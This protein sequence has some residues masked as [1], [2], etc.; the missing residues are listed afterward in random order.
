[1]DTLRSNGSNA[2]SI[3]SKNPS[4]ALSKHSAD[5]RSR[6]LPTQARHN[7]ASKP[8]H[9][10]TLA[11]IG[12][13]GAD[14]VKGAAGVGKS[15]LCNRL[16]RPHF[17]DFNI[18]H[19]S[20]L[21]QADFAC[22]RVINNDHWLYWG[23]TELDADDYAGKTTHVRIIE[24]TVFLDDESFEPLGNHASRESRTEDYAK[25]ALKTSLES[26]DKLMYICRDQ[27]GQES[28]FICHP[29]PDAKT[30]VEAFCVVFDVSKIE[31]RPVQKQSAF[32]LQLLVQALKT[33]KPVFL[34]AT[35][36]DVADPEALRE[37]YKLAQRKELKSAQ[38]HTA[39]VSALQNVNIA[40]FLYLV[41]YLADKS[42][43]RP[44]MIPYSEALGYRN[45][46]IARISYDFHEL[47]A[48]LLPC[49][50]YPVKRGKVTWPIL[51]ADFD[52]SCHPVY[53]AFVAEF[54]PKTAR[55]AFEEHERACREWWFEHDLNSRLPSL[56]E[57]LRRMLDRSVLCNAKW[58]IIHAEL[59]AHP[60]FDTYFQPLGRSLDRLSS[61]IG[62]CSSSSTHSQ[63]YYDD[64][65]PG[66]VLAKPE[67]Q[68]LFQ[69]LQKELLDEI[70][71]E[72]QAEKFRNLLAQ[73][74]AVTPGRSFKDARV[75]VEEIAA[76]ER[77]LPP[78]CAYR[79]YTT[80]Q[81]DLKRQARRNFSELLL[82]NI[83]L[84][85]DLVVDWR[86]HYSDL[87]MIGLNEKDNNLVHE[88]LCQDKRYRDMNGLTDDRQNAISQF[89]SF[90]SL[91]LERHC[92][93]GSLCADLVLPVAIDNQVHDQA[94]FLSVDLE[95]HGDLA[96]AQ[97]FVGAVKTITSPENVFNYNGY[98]VRFNAFVSPSLEL[99]NPYAA[100]LSS[101]VPTLIYLLNSA[102]E[103]LFDRIHQAHFRNHRQRWIPPIF[104]QV[105][106]PARFDS[107]P[108]LH[109][110][111]TKL[112]ERFQGVFVG[113]SSVHQ[114]SGSSSSSVMGH[115]H[116]RFNSTTSHYDDLS[117]HFRWEQITRVLR[118]ACSAQLDSGYYDLRVRLSLFCG[119][120]FPA[121][122]VLMP[123][124]DHASRSDASGR[125]FSMDVRLP[126]DQH[127]V[128]VSVNVCSYHNWLLSRWA[129]NSFQGHILVYSPTRKASWR[130]AKTAARMLINSVDE[131][132]EPSAFFT[133][134]DVNKM[135]LKGSKLAEEI[136]CEFTAV[137]PTRNHASQVQTYVDFFQRLY[138]NPLLSADYYTISN[139]KRQRMSS[140]PS[141]VSSNT[142]TENNLNRHQK[143]YS[144]TKGSTL[145]GSARTLLSDYSNSSP[146]IGS[147]K[148]YL[149]D[150]HKTVEDR[151]FCTQCALSSLSTKN[152]QNGALE[153]CE[154]SCSFVEVNS[155]GELASTMFS[156][157]E[158]ASICSHP[159]HTS[160]DS[161][162]TTGKAVTPRNPSERG[163]SAI[164][165]RRKGIRP[166]S[167]IFSEN[168]L[169]LMTSSVAADGSELRSSPMSM[170]GKAQR[171]LDKIISS[172]IQLR[173]SDDDHNT[174]KPI[175]TRNPLQRHNSIDKFTPPS[176]AEPIRCPLN[177]ASPPVPPPKP[178]NLL[179]Q[180]SQT[181]IQRSLN[182]TP[183]I[184]HRPK[185]DQ[186]SRFHN[187]VPLRLVINPALNGLRKGANALSRSMDSLVVPTV[188]AIEDEPVLS[189]ASNGHAATILS[190]NTSDYVGPNQYRPF[191]RQ[192][193]LR[194]RQRN[195]NKRSL[196]AS[197][198]RNQSTL[199]S[200][201]VNFARRMASS[202]RKKKV[203]ANK[204][205]SEVSDSGLKAGSVASSSAFSWLPHRSPKRQLRAKSEGSSQW[206]SA[207]KSSTQ[208][209]ALAG[210]PS[211]DATL[212]SLC[213]NP[214][215]LPVFLTKCLEFIESNGGMEMEGL[216]RVP[217]NQSQV[218]ELEKAFR[219]SD[220]V[221]LRSINIPVH[222]TATALKKFLDG[223]QEPLI[224]TKLDESPTSVSRNITECQ[225][226]R[227]TRLRQAVEENIP[228]LNRHILRHLMQHFKRVAD[229]S[230]ANSMDMRNLSKVWGPTLFR[231][232]FDSF[233]KMASSLA[234]F[235]MAAYVMLTN[236]DSIFL[237]CSPT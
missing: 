90:V 165:A 183:S 38:I 159:R 61:G 77:A 173:T 170:S 59:E 130:H 116:D 48:T 114:R 18:E 202:W 190:A 30:N 127:N 7:A 86:L 146:S 60:E 194:D 28:D 215:R 52:L 70:S 102:E 50:E 126:L 109:Q 140:S 87:P 132:N 51:L 204:E 14:T 211:E 92:A 46:K 158:A 203:D 198:S 209:V 226:G 139:P 104:V 53:E 68:Q 117:L 201:N 187:D 85:V 178:A 168:S 153:D 122:S 193:S 66:E 88:L 138:K 131:V 124:L 149:L 112:A 36:C 57:V 12:L 164:E 13:S 111:G 74:G 148:D 44:R 141:F 180:R 219:K 221:D 31:G 218:A 107:L 9:V 106:E 205:N 39:E 224:P 75:M 69:E 234:R 166:Q 76:F 19:C 163:G 192:V 17:C 134:N 152:T 84:F 108:S 208:S 65:I 197:P 40:D 231:P 42:K 182:G 172:F 35:K 235:E 99:E 3:R 21:S 155:E 199:T 142:F 161:S 129:L 72:R 103:E 67:A 10:N 110:I 206:E 98:S 58:E 6:L 91:P 157:E 78:D 150:N 123:F 4:P 223:L 95:I 191:R 177:K 175:H 200:P 56:R 169:Q 2:S 55:L 82:E 181:P 43:N 23:E 101:R 135:L 128:R 196:F 185:N 11:I 24:Q 120:P 167:A 47:I 125:N 207:S 62:S 162:T 15:T 105:C 147:R 151:S 174:S 236:C 189:T 121:E 89:S 94:K 29:L 233:E 227:I 33:K 83:E 222:A 195:L 37:F 79:I 171:K 144:S 71:L 145:T 63:N 136:G 32:V 54:G 232:N 115:L 228:P 22:S 160:M 81:E 225:E 26:P 96:L 119:D 49:E 5:E 73:K 34:V 93:A 229:R 186:T 27:L 118:E 137:S 113:V 176:S 220:K 179:V 100:P 64:R 8:R 97:E 156:K 214:D 80:F 16:V 154:A 25:R 1:M 184:A 216:Y 133:N 217:G 230:A 210:S 143:F 41:A 45:E 188:I 212:V 20:Y 213:R 237:P